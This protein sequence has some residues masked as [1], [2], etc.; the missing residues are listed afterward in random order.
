MILYLPKVAPYPL[1]D[2][3]L[4]IGL[5]M[6]IVISIVR[7]FDS[8]AR[9]AMRDD[10]VDYMKRYL[11]P[12]GIAALKRITLEPNMEELTIDEDRAISRQV[13]NDCWRSITLY[14]AAVLIIISLDSFARWLGLLLFGGFAMITLFDILKLFFVGGPGTLHTVMTRRSRGTLRT[15][16]YR[17]G[18]TAVGFAESMMIA[19][20]NFY[21]YFHFFK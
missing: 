20:Y 11:T 5:V 13:W 2:R 6:G 10:F 1:Q 12:A 7:V 8:S 3:F 4:G 15:D 9:L 19:P 18:M 16:A 14:G 21:L 17:G